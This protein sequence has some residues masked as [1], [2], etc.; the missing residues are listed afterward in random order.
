MTPGTGKI[1]IN[2]RTMEDYFPMET[3]KEALLQPLVLTNNA[4]SYDI[5]IKVIGGGITGQAGAIRHGI[6]KALVLIDPDLRTPLKKAGFVKRDPR[7]KE[8]KKYGQPGARKR[9]QFSKR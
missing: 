6:T 2:N 9:F 7:Q 1:S 5:K 4:Q 8:R 3:A